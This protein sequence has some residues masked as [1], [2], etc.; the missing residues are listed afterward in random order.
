MPL[1]CLTAFLKNEIMFFCPLGFPPNRRQVHE[2]EKERWAS[3][4]K[5]AEEMWKSEM[6]DRMHA[7]GLVGNGTKS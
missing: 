2:E 5:S 1:T 4:A 7:F 6:E 3:E